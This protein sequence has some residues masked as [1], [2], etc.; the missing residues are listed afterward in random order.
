MITGAVFSRALNVS[1]DK[2]WGAETIQTTETGLAE[3]KP[4]TVSCDA[5]SSLGL[6]GRKEDLHGAA[7]R[8]ESVTTW[9]IPG[10]GAETYNAD[11]RTW[12]IYLYYSPPGNNTP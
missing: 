5:A 9:S 12:R 11:I 2:I 7:R 4:D 1:H 10:T 6:G 3:T 8:M